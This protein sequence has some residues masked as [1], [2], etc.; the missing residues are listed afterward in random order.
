M[1]QSTDPEAP[2]YVDPNQNQNDITHGGSSGT[3]PSGPITNDS[4][5]SDGTPD[6]SG[7]L[8]DGSQVPI[9]HYDGSGNVVYGN[10]NGGR[11]NNPN[12]PPLGQPS[13]NADQINEAYRTAF[14]RNAS[15]SELASEQENA[16][17]YGAQ[18]ILNS[19]ASRTNDTPGSGVAGTAK[20]TGPVPTGKS[21]TTSGAPNFRTN[22]NPANTSPM[23]TDPSQQ[24][25]ES[26]ALDRYHQLQNPDPNSGTGLYESYA[27]QLVDQLKAAP[28][29]RGDEATIKAGAY[30]SIGADEQ[31][32]TQQWMDE[33]SKRGIPPSSG[34][35][36]QG[37]QNIKDQYN[38]ARASVDQQFASNAI[39]MGQNNRMNALGVLGNLATSEN[40]RLNSAGT[41]AAI[42]YNLTQDAFGRNVAAVQAGGNPSVNASTAIQL[43]Q[44]VQQ[45]NSLSA[46]QKA[47]FL[48]ELYQFIG[49][50]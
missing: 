39:T 2:D 38:K 42:P 40:T 20:W 3:P 44:A 48:Q 8:N 41:Y 25:L 5:R 21:N 17:K 12:A 50:F 27:K 13:L 23:F 47:Q 14:G 26:Y 30:N 37:I 32:T 22:T 10:A 7:R 9:E 16:N 45:S 4:G 11:S 34:I 18:G 31:T 28:Y 33:M 35:A 1:S 49:S 46:Q 24:L 36:L 19:I 15:A 29:S 6:P 43:A